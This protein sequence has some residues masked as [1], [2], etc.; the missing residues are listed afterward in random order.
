MLRV[1]LALALALVSGCIDD[2]SDD[3]P[4]SSGPVWGVDVGEMKIEV[5]SSTYAF[6]SD[7]APRAGEPGMPVNATFTTDNHEVLSLVSSYRGSVM[8]TG[9]SVGTAHVLAYY[10]GA[11]QM[12]TIEVIAKP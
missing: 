12:R 10:A 4:E 5:G 7:V 2:P 6:A 11:T 8:V 1:A 9:L 3:M